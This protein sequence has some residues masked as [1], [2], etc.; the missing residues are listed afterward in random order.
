MCRGGKDTDVEIR[1]VDSPVHKEGEGR[2]EQI[3][4]IALIYVYYRV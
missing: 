4:R 2:E 3:E 1:L